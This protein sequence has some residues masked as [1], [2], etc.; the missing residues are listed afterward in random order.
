MI[1]VGG[2]NSRP[3]GTAEDEESQAIANLHKDGLWDF[4]YRLIRK[5][6]HQNR[7]NSKIVHS[8]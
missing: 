3:M 1:P 8:S 6:E 2:Y 4:I 7:K 5:T